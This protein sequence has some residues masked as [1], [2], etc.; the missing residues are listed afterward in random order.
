MLHAQTPP[1]PTPDAQETYAKLCSGCHGADAHGS[2]QGPGLA[3]NAS[4]GRR[5]AQNLRNV[6]VTGIPAAGMPAFPLPEG[7]LNALVALVRSL[8]AP[9]ADSNVAGDR[10]AGKEFF[11]GK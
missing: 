1:A 11:F 5:S 4:V 9:A 3:G 6:I 8:N 10:A 7:T 2:Q